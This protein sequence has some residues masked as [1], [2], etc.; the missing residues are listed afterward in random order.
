MGPGLSSLSIGIFHSCAYS[1]Q[2]DSISID[3]VCY[4]VLIVTP[5][6]NYILSNTY[7]AAQLGN[8]AAVAGSF[9]PR[10]TRLMVGLWAPTR[11][12]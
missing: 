6:G 9:I 3:E 10:L 7:R 5:H 8:S 1:L 4:N 12:S 11:F 2:L